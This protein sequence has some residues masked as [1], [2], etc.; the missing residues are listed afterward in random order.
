MEPFMMLDTAVWI[1]GAICPSA[2][3]QTGTGERLTLPRAGVCDSGV[4][5]VDED[6]VIEGESEEY[7]G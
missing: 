6:L 4:D 1:A 3:L 7:Q 5:I 2:L